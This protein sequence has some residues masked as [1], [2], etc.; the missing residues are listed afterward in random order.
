MN[1]WDE[2]L[3]TSEEAPV[4]SVS[5]KKRLKLSLYLG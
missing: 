5:S 2:E 1:A 4:Y 3:V